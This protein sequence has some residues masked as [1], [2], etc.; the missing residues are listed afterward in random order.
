MTHIENWADLEVTQNDTVDF[1]DF[2][3]GT[4]PNMVDKLTFTHYN[5][6]CSLKKGKVVKALG[7]ELQ[8]ALMGWLEFLPQES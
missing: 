8:H 2:Y 4:V 6:L 7:Y 5:R 1:T 3:G